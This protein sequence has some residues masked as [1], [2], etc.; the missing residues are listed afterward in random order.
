[1]LVA[2]RAHSTG[3]KNE[4]RKAY[5]GIAPARVG[6]FLIYVKNY[7]VLTTSTIRKRN[8]GKFRK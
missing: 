2:C 3:R 6:V 5:L 4:F 1:V 7:F 8:S